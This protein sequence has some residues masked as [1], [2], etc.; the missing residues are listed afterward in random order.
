MGTEPAKFNQLANFSLCHLV[1][2]FPG[3]KISHVRRRLVKA[4]F[5]SGTF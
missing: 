1:L 3:N 2:G 5:A 4:P